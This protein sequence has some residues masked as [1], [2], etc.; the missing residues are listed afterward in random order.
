M[1]N[2]LLM[3]SKFKRFSF[4]CVHLHFEYSVHRKCMAIVHLAVHTPHGA[5]FIKTHITGMC[6]LQVDI[7][8]YIFRV[9]KKGNICMYSYK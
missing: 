4:G 8:L 1:E 5:S 2:L 6:H 3:Y 9:D 7:L